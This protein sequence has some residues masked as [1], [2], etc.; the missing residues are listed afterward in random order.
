ME[1]AE[2][3]FNEVKN[4][5]IGGTLLIAQTSQEG[6]NYDEAIAYY[7][8]IIEQQPDN[9]E[10]WLNK[11][12]CMI[13]T[14]TIQDIKIAE[15]GTCWKTAIKFAKNPD[16]MKK[17]VS[18]EINTVV[19]GFYPVLEKFYYANAASKGA[20]LDHLQRF[21]ILVRAQDI[22]LE[23]N[24][25]SSMVSETGL[26]LCD[27][28]VQSLV[29]GAE[30]EGQA[31]VEQ[32]TAEQI[33]KEELRGKKHDHLIETISTMR[34]KSFF[35]KAGEERAQLNRLSLIPIR[36]KFLSA[37][38]K[39]L[40]VEHPDFIKAKSVLDADI[41]TQSLIKQKEKEQAAKESLEYMIETEAQRTLIGRLTAKIF[42]KDDF[43]IKSCIKS[44][45]ALIFLIFI[46]MMV[47]IKLSGGNWSDKGDDTT[48]VVSAAA[49]VFA[50]IIHKITGIMVRK[51]IR[52][53]IQVELTNK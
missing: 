32:G 40:G 41:Q 24:P 50:L 10:A 35:V 7:N 21:Q 33:R 18:L 25:V 9:A 14:S 45:L 13:S 46:L 20:M 44:I 47:F 22:A 49:I 5:K 1:E 16:A 42:C 15:A 39:V 31:A 2:Y 4:S 17:R 36:S 43:S 26:K 12:S 3:Q 34:T 30:I 29:K 23:L 8:K 48:N 51:P 11:G 19:L 53:R 52:A 6:G 37:L 28:F 38:E 27:R